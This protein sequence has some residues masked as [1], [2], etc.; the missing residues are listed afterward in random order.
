MKIY[1]SVVSDTLLDHF[2]QQQGRTLMN[3]AANACG[4]EEVLATAALFWPVIVEDEDCVFVA[5]F[6]TQSLEQLKKQFQNDKREIERWV[7]AWS[8]ADFFLL[9]DTPSV[10]DD[11][12]IAAFGET[13]RF[14]WSFRLK[15]LFP[16]RDFVV[17][18]SEGIEGE[19]G[20]AI[21]FYQRENG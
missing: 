6:Y 19:R 20:L 11:A 8:L 15:T 16:N 4:I 13:L 21:T 17:E 18:V 7:N 10:Q 9:A 1:E 2:S 3:H 5:E 14:F 12:L